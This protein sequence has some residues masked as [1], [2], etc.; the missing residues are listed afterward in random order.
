MYVVAMRQFL[1]LLAAAA[2]QIMD[3][4]ASEGQ[5]CG[6][7]MSLLLKDMPSLV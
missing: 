2:P 3:G 1:S 6:L 7:S 5:R 4:V